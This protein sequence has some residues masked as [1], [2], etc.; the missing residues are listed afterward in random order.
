M[1]ILTIS[2][3]LRTK[4]S[5][6]AVL[7]AAARLAPPDWEVVHY[8]GL[9]NLPH[10]NPDM[11]TDRPPPQVLALR[12]QIGLCQGLLLCSPEYARGVAGTLKNALDWLVSS[13]EFPD[14][15][16][17]LINASQRATS[18]DAHLRLTLTTMSAQLIEA[19]SITLPLLGRNLDADG[20][21]SDNVLSEQLR[22]ALDC[23]AHAIAVNR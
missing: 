17:A 20:I 19:A 23:F 12:E 15:P 13:L 9:A 10:F 21:V 18:A 14:K 1:R 7:I 2:G 11:D 22:A 3:S 5:N 8:D 4:S 6:T 16:V